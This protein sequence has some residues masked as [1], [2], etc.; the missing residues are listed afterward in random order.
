MQDQ[1]DGGIGKANQP[2]HDS[3]AADDIQLIRFRNFQ[4][5]RFGVTSTHKVDSG[6]GARKRMLALVRAG[7]QGY[8]SI[9]SN[10]GLLQLYELRDLHIGGVQGF[11]L[12]DVAGPHPR[13]IEGTII[14]ERML[15]APAH[16]EEEEHAESNKSVPHSSIVSGA[17]GKDRK[18]ALRDTR[19]K[20]RWARW[21]KRP[22]ARRKS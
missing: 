8:A 9:V 2:Q 15:V 21:G 1:I 4:N 18:C 14:R 16:P 12:L 5:H 7:N 22:K 19:R 11:E 3:I 6:I 20:D 13:L 17:K 10:P